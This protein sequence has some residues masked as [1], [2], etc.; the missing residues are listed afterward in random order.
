MSIKREESADAARD[1]RQQKLIGQTMRYRNNLHF[2]NRDVY[3]RKQTLMNGGVVID[4]NNSEFVI[5]LLFHGFPF[6]EY[7]A[8]SYGPLLHDVG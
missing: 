3:W 7:P 5:L 6:F 2:Y 4:G 1:K 8:P